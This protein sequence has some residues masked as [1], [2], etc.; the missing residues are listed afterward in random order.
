VLLLDLNLPDSQGL[1]TLRRV[2]DLHCSDTAIIVLTGYE[3]DDLGDQAIRLGAQDYLSKRHVTNGKALRR[4]MRYAHERKEREVLQ[5]QLHL[6]HREF[7]AA[8]A[9]Q[10]HFLPQEVPRLPGFDIAADCQPAAATGGDYY[11]F[12]P[13]ADGNL[14]VIIADVLAHGFGPALIMASV[15]RT[16]RTL[17]MTHK[18]PG[19]ILTLVNEAVYE[20]TDQFMTMFFVRLN[21]STRELVYAAAGHAAYLFDSGGSL[22][23]RLDKGSLPLGIR[24]DTAYSSYAGP[25]VLQPGH[26]LML[27]T[28]GF[29]EAWSPDDK[30]FGLDA[31]FD[32]V[33]AQREKSAR[34]LIDAMSFTVRAFCQ[35][36]RPR[37]D[38]TAVVVRAL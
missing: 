31:V 14:G 15:R 30:M 18:D 28:D 23:S 36:A 21:P 25:V 9:I 34:E 16:L 38:M 2:S 11:D 32:L 22:F 8:R 12:I 24:S 7:D 27:L 20:D 19:K 35:P 10:R 6:T 3:D 5:R 33:R 29:E 13:M 4:C 37:D 1:E 17:A 26:R